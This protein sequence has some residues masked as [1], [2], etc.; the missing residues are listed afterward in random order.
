MR[1]LKVVSLFGDR[2]VAQAWQS[3]LANLKLKVKQLAKT[4]GLS[5]SSLEHLIAEYAG[6]TIRDLKSRL[7]SERLH[8]ARRQLLE[9]TDTI[10]DIRERAG[11]AYESN[12]RRDFKK[13]FKRPPAAFRRGE[14]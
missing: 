5:E 2:R 9:T 13:L 7:K 3:L 14:E 6:T 8:E 12:F 10:L 1:D 11:Y 4:V